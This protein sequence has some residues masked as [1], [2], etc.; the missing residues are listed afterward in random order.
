MLLG[1]T[2]G[3]EI[4]RAQAADAAPWEQVRGLPLAR[5]YSF[6]EIGDVSS[7]LHLSIDRLGRLTAIQ[8]SSFVVFDDKNWTDMLDKANP[9][10]NIDQIARAPDGRTYFGGPGTWGYLDYL[11]SGLVSPHSLRPEKAPAWVANT[12]F[13][14]IVPTTTGVVFGGSAGV[15][16]YDLATGQQQFLAAPDVVYVFAVGDRVF[17]S[18]YRQGLGAVDP[19]QDTLIPLQETPTKAMIVERSATWDADH[20]LVVTQER[21]AGLFDGRTITPWPTDIDPLLPDGIEVMRQLDHGMVAIVVKTHGMYILD[22]H[23]HTVMHC[24]VSRFGAINDVCLGEPGVLWI[25]SAEGITKLLYRSPVTL[26]DHRLGLT[27]HWPD[28]LHHGGRTLIVSDG[29]VFEAVPGGP[30]EPTQFREYAIGVPDGVW[31]MASTAHGLLYGNNHGLFHRDDAT[32][33][34]DHVLTKLNVSRI[35]VTDPSTQTCLVIG[36]RDIAAVRWQDGR[37]Q[38]IAPRVEGIGFPSVVVSAAPDSVWFEL[39]VNRVG[40][41]TFRDGRLHTRVIDEFPWPAKVWIGLGQIGS[42]VIVTHG[43]GER[44]YFDEKLDDFRP[45]PELERLFASAPYSVQ[46]PR[47]DV[48]GVIWMPHPRGVYRMVPDGAGYRVETSSLSVIR[49]N[50]PTVQLV[51]RND[52]W[53]RTSRSLMHVDANIPTDP[54]PVLR[55]VLTRVVDSRRDREIYNALLPAAGTLAGIPYRSNSLNFH[56]FPGSA[57]LL[58]TPSYQYRLE[59]YSNA[60]SLP[61]RDTTISL[62]RLKEGDYRMTVRLLD[63]TGPIGEP[64]S[65][66]FSIEAPW[67]RTWYSYVAGIL[68]ALAFLLA[69][70]RWV[71]RRAEKRNAQLETL[72][73]SRTGELDRT[74]EQLRASVH[75]AQEAARAKS[76]FLATMSHEI[77]TPMNGVIGMSNVLLDTRLDPEQR[78]FAETIRN[79]AEGL[80]TVLNDILDFS[81]LEAGKLRVDA[82]DFGLT[83]AVEESLELLAPRAAAKGIE[84]ASLIAPDVPSHVHGDPGRVRQVLLNLVGNA[85][86][87][88]EGGEVFVTVSRAPDPAGDHRAHR[89]QFDVSDTGIGIAADV[90]ARLFQPFTQA[91]SSTTR[92]FGGTGLGLA[93]CRQIVDLLGGTIGVRSEPGDG[94][95]FTFTIPLQPAAFAAVPDAIAANLAHLRGVRAL[96]VHPSPA[97]RKVIEHHAAACGMKVTSV[98]DGPEACTRVAERLDRG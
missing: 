89:L 21:V 33:A 53:V 41:V 60:W 80:L 19:A 23:G 11:P 78:E 68:I 4:G 49:D 83:D 28:V 5:S 82:V 51:D 69:S 1:L 50:Y 47:Q 74:N 95:T 65:F 92:R 32:G 9:D 71:L 93:I 27:V 10:R 87:F 57:S 96:A 40:R 56:F 98:S 48:H 39:G 73:Q 62:T 72:V 76:Q 75:E 13:E 16:R 77:R 25:S 26:F 15:V 54:P 84:L 86:K 43:D 42:T 34:V 20:V 30:G 17:V 88:T 45:A 67:Y 81:K 38:E 66:S 29:R 36:S 12:T 2:A 24:A 70:N 35:V 90:Q 55:P 14:W 63:S 44:L 22:A 61:T 85:V 3:T 52:V 97:V 91:D 18:S 79:S 58:H 8:E 6:E 59:G 37:W 46:R 94:S 31:T 7:G 64:T